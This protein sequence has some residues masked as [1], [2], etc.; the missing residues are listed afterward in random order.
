M[1]NPK[2]TL[3]TVLLTLAV[4]LGP[5]ST[6]FY[7]PSLPSLVDYFATNVTR[8]QLTLSVFLVGFAVG[9]LF[10]GPLSD[11]YGRRPVMLAGV[12]IFTLASIVCM[13]STSIEMLIAARLVQAIGACAGPVLGRAVVR[14]VHG[15]EGAARMLALIGAAMALAPLIGPVVAGYLTVWFGWQSS[16][17]VLTLYGVAI[18]FGILTTLAETNPHRGDVTGLGRMLRNYR[19]FLRSRV[20]LG[21]VTCNSATFAGLFAFIS[22]SSFVFIDVLGLPPHL[23]GICFAAAVTGYIA[24]TVFSA[25]T[26]MRLGIERMVSIGA[27][28]CAFGGAAMAVLALAGVQTVWSVLIPMT[29]YTAGVGLVMPNSMAG[30]IGPFPTM[31]GAA[32]ALLGFSQMTV[33]A[34][35]GIAVGAAFDGSTRPMAVTIGLTGV[36]AIVAYILMVRGDKEGEAK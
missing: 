27:A 9:Q 11:R 34:L 1:P 32:S 14:D 35:V 21:Y 16:F 6:D 2:S 4:A 12:A 17:L 13:F 26:V 29:I 10:Y 31:A 3:V 19:A 18:L 36:G 20:W 33:A 15:R 5:M 22:G 28:I 8:V 24:G 23:F 7:L 25:R 30:A